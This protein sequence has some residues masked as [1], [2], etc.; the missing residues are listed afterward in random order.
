MSSELL[1]ARGLGKRYLLGARPYRRLLEMIW[2]GSGRAAGEFW[3]V[4]GVDL[5]LKAGEIVGVIGPNGSGKST[6]LQLLCGTTTPTVGSLERR[7][8]V[9][10]LL[11]LGAGFNPE[12]SGRDNV[13]INAAVLGLSRS[14]VEERF[15]DIVAF[16]DLG[17]FIDAPV[18]TYSSGMFMRLAFSVAIHV[19]PQVLIIDEAL[20]VGDRE[21]QHRCLSRIREMRQRGVAILLVSHDLETV[22]RL[23][24]RSLVMLGGEVVREGEPASVVNWYLALATAGYDRTRLESMLRQGEAEHPVATGGA[25]RPGAAAPLFRHGDG[26]ARI[27]TVSFRDAGGAPVEEVPLGAPLTV[28]LEVEFLAEVRE[29]VVGFFLR[30]AWGLDVIGLNTHQEQVRTQPMKAG[31]SLRYRFSFTTPLR[32]GLYALCPSVAHNQVDLAWLDYIDNAAF[33]RVV[34]PQPQ[35]QVFG[36]CL[37]LER[38]VSVERVEP[39]S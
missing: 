38:K 12:L 19:E 34:D 28:E 14:E 31:D 27:R 9:S 26:Q 25:S 4:R 8:R 36:V 32:P 2:P 5:T 29:H 1:V 15:S 22:S 6:L 35:R 24:D 13:F 23:C 11:E 10:A 17:A 18:K 20:A 16:A 7:G 30:D 37:P 33:V 3:A 39:V 21:F